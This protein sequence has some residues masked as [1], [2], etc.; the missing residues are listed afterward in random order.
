M[1]TRAA[2]PVSVIAL[3][4]VLSLSAC[5]GGDEPPPEKSTSSS[6]T[7]KKQS[8]S[9]GA[10]KAYREYWRLAGATPNSEIPSPKFKATMTDELYESTVDLAKRSPKTRVEGRDKLLST[11]AKVKK[12]A[13]GYTATVTTCYE[14][15]SR[16]PALEAGTVDGFSWNKGDD[17]RRDSKGKRVK[18]G[19]KM[20][21]VGRVKRGK[22]ENSKWLADGGD[23]DVDKPCNGT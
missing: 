11:D 22:A 19:T 21:D 18:P 23:V 20:V 15:H 13:K 3:T 7:N 10:E 14:V 9:E 16:S 4:A 1:P 6:T 5:G 2:R 12:T 8:L 17:M